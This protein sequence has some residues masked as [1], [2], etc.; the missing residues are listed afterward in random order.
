[1]KEVT[2]CPICNG[3]S[4]KHIADPRDFTLTQERYTVIQC[5]SCSLGIT[6]PRPDDNDLGK[7][8]ISDEYI[9]HAEKATTVFDK[10]YTIARSHAFNRKERLLQEMTQGRTVL[11]YGCG[12]GDFL[13]FLQSRG[14]EIKGVE[15]SSKARAIAAGK[16]GA[17]RVF[18][19]IQTIDTQFDIITLW[20][21]LEHVPD[22]DET[23][24]HLT[25]RLS[26]QGFLFIAVPNL[27]SWDSNHYRDFWAAYD[28]PRHLWHFTRKSI[29]ALLQKHHLKLVHT[30]PMK[31]DAFYVSLLS[32]KYQKN[33]KMTISGMISALVNGLRSNQNA[34][35]TGEYS[36]LIYIVQHEDH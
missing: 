4:F 30:K 9:S 23:L 14:Y 8:Y 3:T 27:N 15:P 6:S 20:H 16:I 7:Y 36:S 10:I 5:S 26:K 24:T 2:I 33:R 21:V 17:D 1:M 34:Q 28:T 29:P 25:R 31:L 22:L 18:E 11:D 13:L 12:T 19:N 32:E 35:K